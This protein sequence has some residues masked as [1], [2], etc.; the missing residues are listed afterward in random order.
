MTSP[1]RIDSKFQILV[2]G[3]DPEVFFEEF[4]RHL[5]VGHKIQIQ[6][7]GGVRELKGFLK[8]F[9]NL[10]GFDSV[11]ALGIIRDAEESDANSA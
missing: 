4:C 8:A 3:K 7:F 2:E 6:N 11:E 5:H 10:S 9:V 1:K